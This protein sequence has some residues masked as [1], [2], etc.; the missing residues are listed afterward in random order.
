MREESIGIS[1]GLIVKGL[2]SVNAIKN[3]FENVKKSV[4]GVSK[5]ISDVNTRIKVLDNLKE[6]RNSLKEQLSRS[7]KNL[8]GGVALALP[9][10]LA[11]DFEE[12]M[13]DVKKVV[14]FNS[15]DELKKF[16]KDIIALSRKI[17]LSASELATITASGG[18]LGIAK[19]NL[20]KFTQ[21]AAKMGVAFDMSADEAGDSMGKLMNIFKTDIAGVTKLGDAINHLSDNS[22]SKAKEVVEVLKRIGGT[23]QTI[24]LTS[25]Q[26][27][28]LASSFISLGKTPE[29]AATSADTL[30]KRLG[31]I[32]DASQ[33][34]KD[35]LKD[36][37]M[38]EEYIMQGMK[39]DPQKMIM[40]FLE[41][42]SKIPKDKQL[43]LLT[44]IFGV[45]FSGDIAL[46]VNGL[47]TYKKAL[48]DV[49]DENSYK[50]S[51][52]KEF[53]NRSKT[54]ANALTLLKSSVVEI[55]IN[56]GS[57]FLPPIISIVK[58]LSK[59]ANSIANLMS[60][61]PKLS[62]VIG[63]AVAGFVIIKPLVLSVM[64]GFNYL[65]SSVLMTVGGISKLILFIKSL[66]ISMFLT[67]LRLKSAIIF[68]A[69]Y[70]KTI[71]A[72]S[73]VCMGVTKA[74]RAIAIGIRVVSVAMM[75]NPIGLILGA[76]A[77]VAGFV[78][79]NWDK[80][81]AW[82]IAFIEW[83]RPVFEPVVEGVKQ[84]WQ[85]VSAFFGS[86]IESWKNAFSLVAEFIGKVF[87]TP[88]NFIKGL[89]EPL[90]EWLG[91]KFG[92]ISGAL[93][94]V[95][96]AVSTALSWVGLGGDEKI[97]EKNEKK[98]KWYNPF[99]WGDESQNEN[100]NES[101]SFTKESFAPSNAALA[102]TSGGT[103][104]VNFSGDFNIATTNGKFDLAQF[105]AELIQSV[106]RVIQKENFTKQNR[107]IR[108]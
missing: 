2:S 57:M 51:M 69:I 6:S 72:L 59:M 17:P 73:F 103:I 86:I 56:F 82:F 106:K 96:S 88:V 65:T 100:Q 13:A 107:D 4:A 64:L 30:M 26:A 19:E 50:D 60:R 10:K 79:L 63:Y 93:D 24:G 33:D 105:E 75:S 20:L 1:I 27:S 16:S 89:F 61:F 22:A 34:A 36:I 92:W 5:A 104:N 102:T 11:V 97:D 48:S 38:D 74:F 45:G 52:L 94:G 42:T 40:E 8:I 81:K 7:S 55:G 18:Q 71:K 53:E 35:A 98:S 25:I 62:A 90:F 83:I 21:I 46:L 3:G 85:G 77:L 43:S 78:I 15:N 29:L 49:A 23:A 80:V 76:I 84:I 99:S 68:T 31:N 37:G 12:A 87:E 47:D 66:N 32:G 39:I 95:K 14:D 44:K 67:S 41:A 9:V 58:F 28:A 70:Q 108:G 54:T 91:E 101:F